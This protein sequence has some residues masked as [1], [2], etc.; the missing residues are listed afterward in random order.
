MKYLKCTQHQANLNKYLNSCHCIE[1]FSDYN[2]ITLKINNKSS[3]K[4]N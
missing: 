3:L 2:T 4:A 1:I